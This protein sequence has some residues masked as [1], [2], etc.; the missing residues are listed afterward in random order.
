MGPSTRKSVAYDQRH[1]FQEEDHITFTT[2]DPKDAFRLRKLLASA[3]SPSTLAASD[4]ELTAVADVFC[5]ALLKNVG[6]NNLA[7]SWSGPI[8]V[9][10][11]SKV[12]SSDGIERR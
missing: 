2:T 11:L 1:P 5:Q 3:F 8:D 4:K 7:E 6:S 10:K 9:G 12:S